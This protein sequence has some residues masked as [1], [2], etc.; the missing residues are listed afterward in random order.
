MPYKIFSYRSKRYSIVASKFWKTL[1]KN[2]GKELILFPHSSVYWNAGLLTAWSI[3]GNRTEALLCFLHWKNTTSQ[4]P[5]IKQVLDVFRE[6]ATEQ[7]RCVFQEKL[8][9]QAVIGFLLNVFAEFKTYEIYS[10][11]YNFAKYAFILRYRSE[12]ASWNFRS[13]VIHMGTSSYGFTGKLGRDNVNLWSDK[14]LIYCRVDTT[15]SM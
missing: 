6:T 5:E 2:W 12:K 1:W 4:K 3:D 13:H 11:D 8:P 14:R 9:C 15:Q 10:K 7:V